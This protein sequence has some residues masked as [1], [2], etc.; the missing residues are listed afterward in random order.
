M[1][2]RGHLECTTLVATY[3]DYLGSY[4]SNYHTITTTTPPPGV[5]VFTATVSNFSAKSWLLVSMSDESSDIKTPVVI[6]LWSE[7]LPT[8]SCIP[9]WAYLMKHQLNVAFLFAQKMY[10][11]IWCTERVSRITFLMYTQ[12]RL[13]KQII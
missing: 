5:C 12:S 13:D 1:L 9:H 6:N 8:L 10:Y 2:Y 11:L 4:K 7:T 3:T